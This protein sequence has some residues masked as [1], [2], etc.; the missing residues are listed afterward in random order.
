MNKQSTTLL[1]R[2]IEDSDTK[3]GR[4]FDLAIQSLIVFSLITFSF[5]TLPGLSDST[6][7]WLSLAELATISV[8]TIE[9]LLRVYVSDHKLAYIFSF[10]GLVDLIAIIP[11]YIAPGVDLRSIRAFRLLRLFRIFKLVRYSMALRR[12][13]RAFLI[14]REE[15]I[16]FS[17]V[18][19]LLL[20]L[21]A[22]GIYYFE[23]SVQPDKFSS[24]F[25]SL[26]WAV[27]S[28]TTVG[29]GDMYPVTT[30]G[31]MFTF[32]V[33][34]LGVGVISVPAGLIASALSKA[35]EFEE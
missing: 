22:I 13:H 31:K 9:Y 18:T 26:W 16:L 11:F 1:K 34:L 10:F 20:Y 19:M 6:R 29:Y 24:I 28:F 15:I 4:V 14:A 2:T 32:C 33:L 21:S 7:Y 35:R 27:V 12:F 8:F 3:W 5:E 25:H 17:C 30:G 23:H